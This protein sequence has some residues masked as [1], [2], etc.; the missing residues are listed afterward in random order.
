MAS[1]THEQYQNWIATY[2][3]GALAQP[4]C[5]L[6][7]THLAKCSACREQY[8]AE[9]ALVALLP[10]T[11]DPIEPSPETKLK[12]FARVDADLAAHHA[13]VSASVAPEAV[14]APSHSRRIFVWIAFVVLGLFVLVAASLFLK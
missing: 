12:L 3:L 14:T 7:Q 5:D 9:Q 13:N 4:E 11:V 6:M 10:Q 1:V 8:F 2:A